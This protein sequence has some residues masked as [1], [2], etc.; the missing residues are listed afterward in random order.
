MRFRITRSLMYIPQHFNEESLEHIAELIESFP[1]ATIVGREP[2]GRLCANHIPL[3]LGTRLRSNEKLALVGNVLQGHVPRKN[4]SWLSPLA[5]LECLVI[6]QGNDAYI[7]PDWYASKPVDGKVV[8]TWNYSS[9]HCSGDIRII[10]DPQWLREHL[11][12]LTLQQEQASERPWA[13]DD[14]PA[15]YVERLTAVL[16][17]IEVT[18]TAVQAK[19]KMSQNQSSRNRAGVVNGLIA[20]GRT[21]DKQLAEEISRFE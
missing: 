1:L 9:V 5:S 14:A 18:I 11:E 4:T 6:F 10:D 7:S 17:G 19:R 3:M 2:D 12:R 13:V 21:S 15:D 16:V 20:T 8:P